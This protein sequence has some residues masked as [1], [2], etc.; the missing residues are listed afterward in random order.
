M[1]RKTES[2]EM[3]DDGIAL[4][5]LVYYDPEKYLFSEVVARFAKTGE[6][7]PPEFYLILDWKASRARTKHLSRLAEIAGSFTS[8]T[9][10]IAEDLT[11]AAGPEQRLNVLLRKW[12]FSLPTGSTV[13]AI[14]YPDTF[15][16][17]DV[18]VCE[19]LGDFKRLRNMAPSPKLWREY[20]RFRA[21]VRKQVPKGRS[22]RDCDK[23]LW[24]LSKRKQ[25]NDEIRL[26]GSR[27]KDLSSTR[28]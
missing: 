21:A 25:L 13:L 12:R 23:W 19:A 6:L 1:R 17:Y 10:K 8:A 22:L 15:T 27:S 4:S 5:P 18:R 16:I 11:A 3:M 14:L 9:H 20:E 24:G 26:Q 7:S 2:V 28:R